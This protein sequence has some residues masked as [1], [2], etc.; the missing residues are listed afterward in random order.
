ML[1]IGILNIRFCLFIILGPVTYK[2][3]GLWFRFAKL[4]KDMVICDDIRDKAG[5][6]I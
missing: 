5:W 2:V 6:V 4:I 3:T 1:F